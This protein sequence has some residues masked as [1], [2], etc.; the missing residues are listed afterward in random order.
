MA[1]GG[2]AKDPQGFGGWLRR[3][4]AAQASLAPPA[5]APAGERTWSL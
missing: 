1:A 2:G 4:A 5:S 3:C